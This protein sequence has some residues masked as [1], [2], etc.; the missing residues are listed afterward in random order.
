[1]TSTNAWQKGPI[2]LASAP[3]RYWLSRPGALTAGLRALG[4]L[5]LQVLAERTALAANDEA[6]ALH[7]T[8]HSRVRIRE[9]CMSINGTP[10]I[11]ARSVT[12]LEASLGV[13][14]GIRH[15]GSRPLAD[16]LYDDRTVR[17]GPFEVS[18][19]SRYQ[20]IGRLV[21]GQTAWLTGSDSVLARRSVFYRQDQ[22]LLVCEAFLPVF[23]TLQLP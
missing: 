6:R 21:Y 18:R 5:T 9:I 16:L 15:L 8:E 12:S 14:R 3:Q 4:V 1:M 22:A 13:W 17:R 19:V 11:L 2:L 20:G 7:L 23:W 10:C